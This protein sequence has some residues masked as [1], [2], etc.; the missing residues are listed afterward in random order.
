MSEIPRTKKNSPRHGAGSMELE[1]GTGPITTMCSCGSF[2]EIYKQD[3]TFRVQ[4]PESIDPD[5]T[6]PNAPWV[7]SPVADVGSNN[8]TVAR[9]LLQAREMLDAAMFDEELNKEAVILHLHNCKETLLTCERLAIRLAGRIDEI[10][11]QITEQGISTDNHG[12]GLNP[13]PQVQDLDLDCGAFLTQANR[14]IKLICELPAQF[15][16]LGKTDSNF[17]HL[18]KRLS[19]TLGEESPISHFV[20][21]NSGGVRYLI[22]LRNF[23]EHPSKIKTV[24]ENF[25]VLPDGNIQ[26]PT[27]YLEGKDTATPHHIKEETAA[28]VDFIRDIAETMFIHL[29]MYRISKKF[30]FFIQVVPDNE[31]VSTL[32]IRYRLSIDVTRMRMAK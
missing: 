22:E 4:T 13:F 6:N 9:V 25:R 14:A 26:T 24:I 2:L 20:R 12:R 11:K 10:I 5:E 8:L 17:D 28:A 31:I 18:S 15:I 30:P 29:L 1:G 7:A 3:K 16:N 23:H 27:W 19:N 21:E 32:P